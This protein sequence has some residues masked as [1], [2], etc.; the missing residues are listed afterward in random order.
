MR[1]SYVSAEVHSPPGMRYH[2]GEPSASYV[3]QS[4]N[5]V[6]T[7]CSTV[8]PQP[9]CGTPPHQRSPTPGAAA[10]S[11]VRPNARRAMILRPESPFLVYS[12]TALLSPENVNEACPSGAPSSNLDAA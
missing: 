3:N 9:F 4:A 6:R 11:S 5:S 1:P 2:V 7:C 8:M 12:K 10:S